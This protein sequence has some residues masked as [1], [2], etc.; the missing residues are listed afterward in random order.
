[1]TSE[2]TNDL[3]LQE[4]DIMDDALDELDEVIALSPKGGTSITDGTSNT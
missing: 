1:M 2:P 4:P 3:E